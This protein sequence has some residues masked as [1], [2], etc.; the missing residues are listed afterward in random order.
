MKK[1]LILILLFLLIFSLGYSEEKI[2]S[3][4]PALTDIV[5]DLGKQDSL[6]GVTDYCKVPDNLKEEVIRIGSAI[7]PSYEKIVR[8]KPDLV[9]LYIENRKIIEFLEKKNYNYMAFKHR[10]IDH[11]YNTVS[12]ISKK[13]GVYKKGRNLIDNSKNK[14]QKL[15][16]KSRKLNKRTV[17]VIIGRQINNLENI[18][19][20]GNDEFISQILEVINLKNAYSG[21]IDY[22]KV[23]IEGIIKM[24]P[25]IIIEVLPNLVNKYGEKEIKKDWK[26]IKYLNAVKYD[27]VF[28]MGEDFRLIPSLEII[29]AAEKFYSKIYGN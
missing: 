5:I 15:R 28:V 17:L 23:S 10:K 2:V 14:L 4:S 7:N 12:E 6:K 22:P 19:I 8:I 18:Y 24:N 20:A 25:D 3:L 13:L 29:E 27:S 16:N 9:L 26:D 1:Y 21:S 11:I